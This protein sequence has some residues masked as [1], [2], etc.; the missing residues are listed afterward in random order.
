MVGRQELQDLLDPAQVACV[1]YFYG[2]HGKAEAPF[3]LNLSTSLGNLPLATCT[4]SPILSPLQ[5]QSTWVALE[6]LQG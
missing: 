1:A 4:T 2:G 3:H 6:F 5:L